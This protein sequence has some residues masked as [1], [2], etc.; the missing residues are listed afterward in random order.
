LLICAHTNIS[1]YHFCSLF[2]R[3]CLIGSKSIQLPK[4][5]EPIN[6]ADAPFPI[7]ENWAWTRLGDVGFTQTGTTP[8]TS[9]PEYFGNDIPF[10]KPADIYQNK[11][12]YE[13]ESLSFDGVP[14]SRLIPAYSILMVC[15][16]GS[17]G[18]CFYNNQDVC[19]NQQINAITPYLADLK[20]IYYSLSS[21]YFYKMLIKNATGTAT[22]IINKNSWENILMPVPPL[23]EQKRIVNR[24][25]ELKGLVNKLPNLLT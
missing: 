17:I 15:I 22:A 7:P 16:G 12:D 18:K 6:P 8:N 20:Y 11:I 4:L 9:H 13:N 1:I 21:D 10:I 5:N 14:Y 19:C 3:F 25:E 2:Y 23:T 24:L